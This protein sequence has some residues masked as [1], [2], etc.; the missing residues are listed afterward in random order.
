MSDE[1]RIIAP[2]GTIGILGGG[3]LGRMLALAAARLG[4]KTHVFAPEGDNPAFD[5]AHAHTCAAYDDKDAL[6]RFAG[7]VDVVTY[8]FE[9]VP[10]ESVGKLALHVPVR[11]DVQ[12]LVVAQDRWCEKTFAADLGVPMPAV[13]NI[14]SADDLAPALEKV[15]LP[16]VLKTRRFG[17]DGKGQK[18]LGPGDDVALAWRE[19]GEVPC[20]LEGFVD[21]IGEVSVIAARG[22]D[23]SFVAYDV[24]CN[25]HENH[26]LR[27]SHVPAGLPAQTERQARDIAFRIADALEYVGVLAIELF[28]VE[29]GAGAQSLLFNEMAPRVHNSGHW[30]EAACAISQFEMHIRAICG[31]PLPAPVRHSDCTMTNILGHEAD[32]WR[33]LAAEENAVLHLYGKREARAGRKMGHITRLR[34]RAV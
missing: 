17:Y 7:A 31:W 9:N 29:D 19:L 1:S 11:P 16:A 2:G 33:A 13:A 20:V 4:L 30:T 22:L 10:A 34:P 24:P 28:V 8:E 27:H 15:G 25:V 21:F 26:I 6:M 12:A 23:G 14:E 32:D 5:V 18:M 3:Q